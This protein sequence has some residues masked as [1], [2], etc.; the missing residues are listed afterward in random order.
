MAMIR[1]GVNFESD[2]WGDLGA[3]DVHAIH[4]YH[5]IKQRLVIGGADLSPW[6]LVSRSVLLILQSLLDSLYF[7]RIESFKL[8]LPFVSLDVWAG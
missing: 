4:R 1:G 2:L 5:N 7:A 8:T 6:Q 3:E